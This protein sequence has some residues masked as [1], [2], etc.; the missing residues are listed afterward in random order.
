MHAVDTPRIYHAHHIWPTTDAHTRHVHGRHALDII[1]QP[2]R[3]GLMNGISPPHS[4]HGNKPAG[5]RGPDRSGTVV[6]VTDEV[7]A[8]APSAGVSAPRAAT[9]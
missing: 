2:T 4:S 3:H 8:S 5:R 7:V 1:H 6:V 9:V